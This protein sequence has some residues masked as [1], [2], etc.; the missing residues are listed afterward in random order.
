MDRS[1]SV[2]DVR[3]ILSGGT[4]A[5]VTLATLNAITTEKL[6]AQVLQGK[7]LFYDAKDARLALQEYM[8]CATCH[9]DGGQDGRVWDLTGFGEGLR[10]TITLKGHGNHGMLHW[11]GNFDEVQD[12]EGQIR[13][14]A[15]GTGLIAGGSPHPTLGTPNAGRSADL[16]A[17]AAYVKS[18]TTNGTSPGR[19]SSGGLSSISTAGQQIFRAQNCAACHSGTTFTNSAL[20]VFANIGTL[21]PSSGT[22]L[23]APLTGLDVPTLRGVWATAPYLH[24]GSAATLTE[25]ITAHQGVTLSAADMAKLVAFVTCIDDA[26]TSA[27]LPFTLA[28]STPLTTVTAAFNVTAIFNSSATGFA[29][30]DVVVVNGATSN[31]TGSRL[32]LHLHG[33][34]DRAPDL[35]PSACP[36]TPPPTAPRSA[37]SPQTS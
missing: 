6:T 13:A 30:T 22:R 24:D 36:P 1:I 12:F 5:P 27:P 28:L 9:N 35:S 31:F 2:H 14:L 18:L 20:N 7:K 23:G 15:G 26:P 29:L 4:A 34:S 37:T 19:T 25:A 11:T 21:K 17:L 32:G 3:G 10:N 16:D 33:D 8:S